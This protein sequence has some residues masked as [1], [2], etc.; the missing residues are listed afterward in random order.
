MGHIKPLTDFKSVNL[1]KFCAFSIPSFKGS[2]SFQR[3]TAVSVFSEK[4]NA[5]STLPKQMKQSLFVYE[6]V[7]LSLTPILSECEDLDS[8]VSY[9]I[10]LSKGLLS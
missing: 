5:G 9:P 8:D 10:M 1:T 3:T 4:T 7:E 2:E 6:S